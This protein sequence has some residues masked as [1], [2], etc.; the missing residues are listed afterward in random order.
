MS[1]SDGTQQP[2]RQTPPQTYT[3]EHLANSTRPRSVTFRE[4]L[5]RNPGGKVVKP[6]LRAS[7]A[8]GKT[9]GETSR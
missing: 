5:P 4:T 7:E 6:L 9:N 1:G 8:T 2:G 3:K